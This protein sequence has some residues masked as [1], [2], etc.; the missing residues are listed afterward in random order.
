MTLEDPS[1]A[2]HE[3]Q[4]RSQRS[5]LV[6][7]IWYKLIEEDG[8]APPMDEIPTEGIAH[9]CDI[10]A[11]GIGIRIT[12]S[13]PAGSKLFIEIATGEFTISAVGLVVHSR[14][15][16]E[17]RYQVGMRFLVIPPNDR[18]LLRKLCPTDQMDRAD[19]AK[20]ADRG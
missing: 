7:F 2:G 3:N 19:P 5:P 12:H 11:G 1:G 17:G 9:S 6:R 20:R 16:G 14:Q 13:Y 10:A 15:V 4:R 8:I 18:I